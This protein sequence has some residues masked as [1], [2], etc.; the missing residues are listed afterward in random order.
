[1]SPFHSE[2]LYYYIVPFQFGYYSGNG[3]V[4]NL[5]LNKSAAEGILKELKESLWIDRGTRAIFLDFTTYNAN[6]NLFSVATFLFEFPAAG[7][8]FPGAV[9]NTVELIPFLTQYDFCI[10]GFQFIF[11]L[12]TLFYII[13]EL[14][15]MVSLKGAYFART[16]NQVDLLVIILSL[17]HQSLNIYFVLTTNSRLKY[18]I[19][20]KD[21]FADFQDLAFASNLY[22]G[23]IGFCCFFTWIKLFKFVS[24]NR[25]MTQ[26]SRTLSK[27]ANDVAN[28]SVMF[29]IIFFGF[30]QAG[31]L[32][33]GSQIS[34]YGSFPETVLT[35]LRLILGDFVYADLVSANR[36]LGPVFFLCY[37]FFCIFFI[38]NMFLAIIN[39]S[40]GAV[41]EEMA[42]EKE[43]LVLGDFFLE[44]I[45]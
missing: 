16:W 19:Q 37:V 17:I 4:Q 36:V 3:Y 32:W 30:A 42:Q 25:T 10:L 27:C 45:I 44:E 6:I 1:M 18:L 8:V 7:G 31:Y 26:L 41:K 35:L 39:E 2:P 12:F 9:F 28:F 23:S 22:T 34:D 29:F 20:V 5:P 15:E 43:G 11:I 40:Y 14:M 24:F 21:D 38:L 13:E 33:F